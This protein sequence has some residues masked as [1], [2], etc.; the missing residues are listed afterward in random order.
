MSQK[1]LL[2]LED[3]VGHEENIIAMCEESISLIDD[4]DI[5]SFLNSE[6]EKHNETKEK[7]MNILEVKANE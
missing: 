7:L 2:Y 5:V 6:I 4:E 1:E 3:A